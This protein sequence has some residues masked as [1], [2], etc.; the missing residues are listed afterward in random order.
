VSPAV[1]ARHD[2][3]PASEP[4]PPGPDHGGP[5]V[6]VAAALMGGRVG[7]HLGLGVDARP[8]AADLAAAR[9]TAAGILDRVAAW[10]ER[11]SRFTSR[12][13]LSRLNADRR[14]SV[15][16]GPTLTAVLDWG[17]AAEARTDGLVDVTLLD[18]RL[19]AEGLADAPGVPSCGSRAW[20]LERSPR[21]AHVRRPLGLHFDLDGV[22]KGW[23][24]DRALDLASAY[25]SAVIDADGDLAGVLERGRRWRFGVADPRPGRSAPLAVLEPPSGPFGLAT[26]GRSVHRWRVAGELRHHLLDPRTG[27][28]ADGDVVQATVLAASAREAE[29]LAKAVVIAGSAAALA[30]LERPSVRGALLLTAAGDVLATPATVR[31]LA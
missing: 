2:A 29:V 7:V 24:A 20:S 31:W 16:I 21:G 22:A 5:V 6:S 19:A 14:P 8:T 1:A 9:R 17:R 13:E 25:P 26:S 23:L 11:L 27:S 18:A 30:L 4:T 12:S 15:P 28:S 10:A 3:R